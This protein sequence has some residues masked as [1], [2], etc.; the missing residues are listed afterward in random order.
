MHRGSNSRRQGAAALKPLHLQQ[1]REQ[2]QQQ[3]QQKLSRALDLQQRTDRPA[4]MSGAH[5]LPQRL[6]QEPKQGHRV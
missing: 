4:C 6:L 3:E 1:Q 2:Q 5:V